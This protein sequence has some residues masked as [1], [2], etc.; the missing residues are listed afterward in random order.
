MFHSLRVR[1]TGSEEAEE[2]SYSKAK[3][4]KLLEEADLKEFMSGQADFDIDM[5]LPPELAE[6]ALQRERAS[7]A[8]AG[9]TSESHTGISLPSADTSS[10]AA[11]P[12]AA[13]QPASSALA[14][15]FSPR[16]GNRARLA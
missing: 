4:Q 11:A 6:E 10:T 7:A 1:T 5:Q 14:F 13:T 2:L 15:P 9:S 3:Q 8:A 12:P 16:R